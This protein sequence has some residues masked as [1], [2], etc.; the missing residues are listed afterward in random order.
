MPLPFWL[1]SAKPLYNGTGTGMEK[2]THT[3]FRYSDIP[4]IYAHISAMSII[5]KLIFTTGSVIYSCD[6]ESFR[7]TEA[8][9]FFSKKNQFIL[10][11]P[12]P[13]SPHRPL[14]HIEKH[15]RMRFSARTKRIIDIEGG[16][17]TNI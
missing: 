17:E 12:P 9:I 6:S 15:S 11:Q 1:Q 10:P 14:I 4:F 3:L 2:F 5:F 16:D 13:P 8:G 7:Q